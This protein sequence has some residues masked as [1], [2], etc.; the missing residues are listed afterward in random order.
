MIWPRRLPFPDLDTAF[1]FVAGRAT[2]PWFFLVMNLTLMVASAGAGMAAQLG[3]AR[4]LFAM[5]RSDALPRSFFGK[6][7]PK[8]RI[9]RNNVILRR[10]SPLG[11]FLVSYSLG[12]EMLNFAL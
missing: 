8:H 5:G 3:A 9:P 6:V 11:A 7:D 1:V 10:S 4:L 12:A 2:G